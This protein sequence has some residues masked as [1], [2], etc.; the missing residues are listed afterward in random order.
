M[1]DKIEPLFS[2]CMD[3]CREECSFPADMLAVWGGKLICEDCYFEVPHAQKPVDPDDDEEW[4]AW[5]G[6]PRFKPPWDA[7]IE[8]LTA[9]N[10][11][12][13]REV[14]KQRSLR[15]QY[16]AIQRVVSRKPNGGVVEVETVE[17]REHD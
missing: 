13:E 10:K 11:R 6:L 8:A 2:C 16:R 15:D 1:T 12:L 14:Q 3:G 4:L 7:R 17:V 5:H 9:E